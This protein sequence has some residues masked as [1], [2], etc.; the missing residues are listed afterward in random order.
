MSKSLIVSA[1]VVITVLALGCSSTARLARLEP[2]EER[3][4]EHYPGKAKAPSWVKDPFVEKKDR[5]L[6]KGQA[7]GASDLGIC[8]R[9]AKANAV[10]NLVEAVKV[11]ARSEFS[12]ALRGSTASG[13][14]VSRYMESVIAWTTENIDI[15]GMTPEDEYWNKIA[16]KTYG[17]I[18]HKY[19]CFVRLSVPLASVQMARNAAL[20]RSVKEADSDAERALAEEVRRQLS[21]E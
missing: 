14:Q 16:V 1:L 13:M 18:D 3:V 20:T 9:Q 2:G 5:L 11:K 4:V 19:Q 10:Q 8:L 15:T 7:S 12:E 6:F 21:G 17:G